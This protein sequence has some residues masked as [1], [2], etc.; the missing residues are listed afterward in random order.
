MTLLWVL[1]VA[2][3]L[4][5][6]ALSAVVLALVRQ[7]GVLHERIAPLG[8]LVT[9]AGPE[10]GTTMPTLTWQAM[11]GAAVEL[12]NERDRSTLLFFLSPTCP[13]CKKL[14]PVL[15]SLQRDEGDWL[16][17]VLASDGKPK[18]HA[19][20]AERE[21]LTPFPYVLSRALGLEFRVSQL[22]Y[23]AVI[24]AAGVVRAKGLV[25]SREQL[26]SLL[27]AAE[28]G[29]PTIQHFLNGENAHERRLNA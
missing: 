4:A 22:P 13:V 3:V 25:N 6:L 20:F 2:L 10:I 18:E 16:D 12:S 5:V 9:S 23:A 1:N 24:D 19:A 28:T 29:T 21:K 15:F 14:L 17:I 26:E 7:V 8:A 11:D 27:S